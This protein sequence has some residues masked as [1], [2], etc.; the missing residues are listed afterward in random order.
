MLPNIGPMEVVVLLVTLLFWAGV[1]AFVVFVVRSLLRKTDQDRTIATLVEENRAS[2]TPSANGKATR[3]SDGS[4]RSSPSARL[5]TL[6][7]VVRF[8]TSRIPSASAANPGPCC[9]MISESEPC[10]ATRPWASTR[11]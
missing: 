4:R 6:S 9:F 10:P 8:E 2:A 5:G 11:T 3:K 7:R 1:V